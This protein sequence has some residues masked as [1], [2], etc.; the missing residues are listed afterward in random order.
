MRSRLLTAALAAAVFAAPASAQLMIPDSGAGDRIMLFSKADGALLDLDWIT[1]LS[2]EFVFTTPKEAI[3]VNGE[4]WV[5]DQVVDAIHRFDRSTRQFL[6]S[7]T[8][9]S[10]GSNLDNVRGMGFDGTTVYITNAAPTANRG[11]Q[12]YSTDGTPT[13]FLPI[14]SS[15]FDVEPFGAEL[16]IANEG[17]NAIQ[18]WTPDGALLGNFATGVVFPQQVATMADGSILAV[19]SIASAGVEGVYH[20]N[21][22][23]S[24]RAFIDTEVM[25]VQFGEHVPRGAWLLDDGGY[26]ITTDRGVFKAMEIAPGT[27]VFLSIVSGVNAQFIGELTTDE[28][29]CL[30]D[31]NV[32]GQVNSNDISAFLSA[33]LDSVQNGNLIADFNLDGTVNSND[34][35]AFLSMWLSA[36]QGGC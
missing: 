30:A 18:R 6:G 1:D 29:G 19:S 10:N 23:G 32:D 27:F 9:M 3:V 25:K 28:E 11:I 16:L 7:I 24:L 14:P 5:S 22:D 33:W 13:G 21:A 17:V 26:L 8:A 4:I 20:F 34:I 2:G 15:L 36:V 31:Y 35:S 12:M